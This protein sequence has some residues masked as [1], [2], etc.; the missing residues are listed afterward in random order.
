MA[1]NTPIRGYFNEDY[2]K[3]DQRD[4]DKILNY[5]PEELIQ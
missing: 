3:R 1:A 4:I 5:Y 2:F